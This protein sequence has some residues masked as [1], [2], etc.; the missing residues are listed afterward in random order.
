MKVIIVRVG[1]LGDVLH[2][3]PA[4]AALRRARPDCEIDWVVDPRWAPLLVDSEGRGPIVSRVHLAETK[5]WT[6]SPASLSTLRS[7]LALRKQLRAERYDLAVDMQGTLRSAVIAWMSNAKRVVGYG[8]PREA[9]A[10]RLYG[11]KLARRGVHVVEQGAALLG[12]A[13][14][15]PLA[16]EKVELPR[17]AWADEWAAAFIGGKRVCLLAP[18]AGWGAKRW[19][20]QRFGK[21]A[22][23][24]SALGLAVAVNASRNDDAL[25]QE[26]IAASNGTAQI[27]VCNVT[28][29]IALLRRSALVIGG[30]SGTQRTWRRRWVT[31]V[32]GTVWADGSRAEWTVGR[33]GRKICAARRGVTHQLQ[34]QRRSRSGAGAH[35]RRR[36]ARSRWRARFERIA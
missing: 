15:V 35:L 34:T 25:A 19:P 12:D 8:D 10:A 22:Q 4:V 11:E 2:A 29:M 6:R 3:L 7:I 33:R 27:A 16:P 5:L 32:G 23:R 36:C 20:A 17:E 31:P 21:V 13:L 1:A 18:G 26:V 24:L 14:D 9:L 30:D 28:G